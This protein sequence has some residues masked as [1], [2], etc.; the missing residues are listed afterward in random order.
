MVFD[1]MEKL[2]YGLMK[3]GFMAEN[4]NCCTFGGSLSC[5]FLTVSPKWFMA[6]GKSHFIMGQ[7]S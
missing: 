4:R 5:Q 7:G 3:I 6:L 2:I 1:Y